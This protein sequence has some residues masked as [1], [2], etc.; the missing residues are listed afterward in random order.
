MTTLDEYR[1]LIGP[2]LTLDSAPT[3]EQSIARGLASLD[4]ALSEKTTVHRAM[5]REGLGWID[6][7]WGDEGKWP[8]DAKGRRKGGKGISHAMEAR[9]RKDGLSYEQTLELLRKMVYAIAEGVEKSP[10]IVVNRVE[11]VIVGKDGM[12]VHLVK[13]PGSN[14]WALTVFYEW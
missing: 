12:E 13:R 6:F 2:Y 10:P 1:R 11:Q 3:P 7:V 9:Q 14:A 5:Y 4:K 8:P